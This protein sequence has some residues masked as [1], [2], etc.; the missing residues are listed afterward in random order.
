LSL[1]IKD[2]DLK[3][4]KLYIYHSKGNK[5]RV[6]LFPECLTAPLER[7]LSHAKV[8]AANDIANRVPVALPGLLAKKYPYAA[9]VERW[10]W[11]FPSHALCDDARA[12]KL[13]RWRC[14][15]SNVQRAV[16][17]AAIRE[18]RCRAEDAQAAS[19]SAGA[20]AS[21]C[22]NSL[23]LP[24]PAAHPSSATPLAGESKNARALLDSGA[25]SPATPSPEGR[26][27]KSP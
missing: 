8:V 11:L 13:V 17:A 3:N 7:Q 14:H 6:V 15:E 9:H 19:T 27:E 23:R 1:R 4:R 24:E 25:P 5:G 16:K 22:S 12:N 2:L 10:A 26:P 20:Q 21:A 18:S